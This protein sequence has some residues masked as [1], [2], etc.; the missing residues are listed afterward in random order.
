MTMCLTHTHTQWQTLTS[1]LL[2]ATTHKDHAVAP[3]AQSEITNR[4]YRVQAQKELYHKSRDGRKPADVVAAFKQYNKKRPDS[5]LYDDDMRR[6][7]NVFAATK[8]SNQLKELVS[9]KAERFDRGC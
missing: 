3:H 4:N 9:A 6:H 5:P 1:P 7:W 2:Q 8:G